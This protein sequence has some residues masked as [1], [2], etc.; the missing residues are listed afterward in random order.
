MAR[1]PSRQAGPRAYHLLCRLLR[2]PFTNIATTAASNPI[3]Q[4]VHRD[5]IYWFAMAVLAYVL[6]LLM[7]IYSS[8]MFEVHMLVAVVVIFN[9]LELLMEIVPNFPT[10]HSSA[11]DYNPG[12]SNQKQYS[13]SEAV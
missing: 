6:L 7:L 1:L 9:I 11:R 13:S 4:Y 12:F 8:S 3:D 5:L 10:T 2:S